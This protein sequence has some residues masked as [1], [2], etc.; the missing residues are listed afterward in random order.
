M[1]QTKELRAFR[2]LKI[3]F[4]VQLIEKRITETIVANQLDALSSDLQNNHSSTSRPT[5]RETK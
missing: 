3:I 2:I 4:T 5:V 1:V